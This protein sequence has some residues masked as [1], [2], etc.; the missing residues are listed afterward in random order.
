MSNRGRGLEAMLALLVGVLTVI[1]ALEVAAL[2]AAIGH[3]M[4]IFDTARSPASTPEQFK[5]R[6]GP[7]L[8]SHALSAGAAVAVIVDVAMAV[9]AARMSVRMPDKKIR[10]VSATVGLGLLL[11]VVAVGILGS[12]QRPGAVTIAL[13]ALGLWLVARMAYCDLQRLGEPAIGDPRYMAPERRL[14]FFLLAGGVG[15]VVPA[16]GFQIFET[17]AQRAPLWTLVLALV[18]GVLVGCTAA[19]I[20]WRHGSR[21]WGRDGVALPDRLEARWMGHAVLLSAVALIAALVIPLGFGRVVKQAGGPQGVFL[22]PA[23]ALHSVTKP[24]LNWLAGAPDKPILGCGAGTP[25]P[26]MRCRP[27]VVTAEPAQGLRAKRGSTK[28]GLNVL[29]AV[30]SAVAWLSLLGG[31]TLFFRRRRQNTRAGTGRVGGAGGRL[32]AAA[33][34]NRVL[35]RLGLKRRTPREEVFALYRSLAQQATSAGAPRPPGATPSEYGVSLSWLLPEGARDVDG[36]T[37]AY[38]EARYSRH[39]TTVHTVDAMRTRSQR[40]RR[41]LRVK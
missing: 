14:R 3:V 32:T 24:L 4:G 22:G 12:G 33:I 6:P 10:V 7:V 5:F 16:A 39:P 17:T 35:N 19:A 40:L 41:L 34:S 31:V 27:V 9:L 28:S 29:A 30:G 13:G 20:R 23:V 8:F 18:Y 37:R 2:T 38:A 25:N 26:N 21:R 15:S 1:V 36:M 11:V